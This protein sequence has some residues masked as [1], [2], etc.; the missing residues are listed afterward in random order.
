[1]IKKKASKNNVDDED[2]I[3]DCSKYGVIV[4]YAMFHLP[5][6]TILSRK[7]EPTHILHVRTM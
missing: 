5:Q 1:M 3:C 4:T 2:Y 7:V 6:A